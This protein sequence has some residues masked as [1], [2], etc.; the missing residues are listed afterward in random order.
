[1]TLR[2]LFSS[3]EIAACFDDDALIG[4]MLAFERALAR[5][6]GAC[7]AIPAQAAARIDEIG[8][9]AKFDV[10]TL[11]TQARR[12]GTLAI[13]FVRQLTAHVA[14]SDAEASRYVHWGATSQDVLDTAL[15]LSA[16]EASL[17]LLVGWDRLGDAL[18]GLADAHRA[19][20]TVA[21]T[22]LQPATP[23]PFGFKAAVWLDAVTRT[24]A[25][26][27]RASRDSAV[28]QF[29]GASGVLAPLGT[30]GPEVAAA[31]A[32]ELDLATPVTPWHGVRDHVAR[33]GAEVGVACEVT[34]K[35]ALD[36]A[37]LMQPEIG[38]ALEPA[39]AERVGSMFAR[40]AGLRAPGLVAN[41]VAGVA[42]EHERGLGQWQ[43][44]F[45]TL[46]EL[47]AAAGSGAD[48]MIEV[49][50]GLNVD[51]DAMRRNLDA[52]RGFVYAEALTMA[53]AGSLGKVAAHQRVQALCRSAQSRSETL[54]Q[55]LQK[56]AELAKS[57][58]PEVAAR[59][60]EPASQFGS[61][62]TMIDRALDAW[63]NKD[64]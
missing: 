29:G 48:A 13:P 31:L 55:A 32:R 38:E 4:R 64:S 36:I 15:V 51:A 26:L 37:L 57:V 9:S 27:R 35:L 16:Q 10:A 6:E 49:V 3:A 59:I 58:P 30:L 47:F 54:Q 21:R 14:Q 33:L 53:L 52:M 2:D 41:L 7:G 63:R 39:G 22:L 25:G 60:F 24:R 42:G 46:G 43:S 19:T 61:A 56:D 5:A 18:A 23:V 44:Q 40:E 20:P 45:W 28:L 62:T 8:R 12:A 50:T 1:M 17:R 11:V 34:A